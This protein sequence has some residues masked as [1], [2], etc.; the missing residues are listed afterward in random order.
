MAPVGGG[1]KPWAGR[2]RR[3][4]FRALPGG[5]RGPIRRLAKSGELADGPLLAY[6]IQAVDKARR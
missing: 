4:P 5:F 3:G 6:Y 1:G 2:L